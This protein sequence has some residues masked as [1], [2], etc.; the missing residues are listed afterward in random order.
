MIADPR[1]LG[2]FPL[3]PGWLFF[4]EKDAAAAITI[5]A[6]GSGGRVVSASSENREYALAECLRQILKSLPGNR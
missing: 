6:Y 5:K 4:E 1:C 3:F 2:E